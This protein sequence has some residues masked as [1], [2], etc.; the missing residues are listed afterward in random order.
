MGTNGRPIDAN[1]I[2]DVIIKRGRFIYSSQNLL[3]VFS[4]FSPLLNCSRRINLINSLF[5]QFALMVCCS[6]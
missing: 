4:P 2:P 6:F 5:N 1:V 3:N